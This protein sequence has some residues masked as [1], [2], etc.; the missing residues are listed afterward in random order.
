MA[1][2]LTALAVTK[3]KAK[4]KRREI[5]DG[6]GLY[7]IIQPTGAKSWA[8]RYRSPSDGKPVKLTLGLAF[9]A[10]TEGAEP[11]PVLG[12]KGLTLAAAR[13]LAAELQ[14]RIAQGIDP[15][16]EY[17]A[18]KRGTASA[19]ADRESFGAAARDFIRH[20]R[21]E[22]KSWR[23]AAAMLGVRYAEDGTAEFIRG[24]LAER[25][26]NMPVAAITGKMAVA[27]IDEVREEGIPGLPRRKAEPSESRARAFSS[28]L[29][30][31]FNWL[32][33]KDRLDVN[34]LIGRERP[35]PSPSRERVLSDAEIAAFWKATGEIGGPFGAAL[36]LM[37]ITGARRDEV[38][39][40]PKSELSADL[41]TWN[42]PGDRTK[43]GHPHAVPLSPLAREIVQTLDGDG[44]YVFT[45]NGWSPIAGWSKVKRRLNALMPPGTQPWV[46][47]DLR[48]TCA[49]NLQ[50]LGVRLEVTETVLNHI[51]GSRAGITGIYQRHKFEGEAKTAM[52]LWARRLAEIVEGRP[53][54]A[55]A[56]VLPMPLRQ[57]GGAGA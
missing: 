46:I 43:N 35:K 16:A 26:R 21:R 38:G 49:T 54:D 33:K 19:D 32:V 22:T 48:R 44:V 28:V 34:P 9:V 57:G 40:M 15:A 11:D 42:L 23:D 50:K 17:L 8:L 14:H 36:R 5:S 25:W 56:N 12:A 52:E 24:G 37:L 4:N 47:H 3:R 30:R 18:K 51:S 29:S 20:A 53:A 10:E 6:K 41:T 55:N 31:L 39:A 13:R 7:L 27:L 2:G 1:R 45:F